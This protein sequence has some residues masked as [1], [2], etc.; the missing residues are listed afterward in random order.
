MNGFTTISFMI[1]KTVV[2]CT[3]IY[4]V[5]RKERNDMV[6]TI[7]EDRSKTGSVL[8]SG[9]PLLKQDPGWVTGK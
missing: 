5:E 6:P 7:V 9:Q 2:I 4:D 8:M 1:N 3:F